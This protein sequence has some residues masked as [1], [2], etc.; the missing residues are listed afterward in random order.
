MQKVFAFLAFFSHEIWREKYRNEQKNKVSTQNEVGKIRKAETFRG[1]RRLHWCLAGWEIHGRPH[2][3]STANCDIFAPCG[4]ISYDPMT[5]KCVGWTECFQTCLSPLSFV[6][7]IVRTSQDLA[8]YHWYDCS[9][10]V[11][12]R[13]PL[14][15]PMATFTPLQMILGTPWYLGGHQQAESQERKEAKSARV[16]TKGDTTVLV[17]WFSRYY[18]SENWQMTN[19]APVSR[20]GPKSETHLNQPQC[21]RCYVSFNILVHWVQS[22][23]Q[24]VLSQLLVCWLFKAAF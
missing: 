21:F 15:H 7:R 1:P 2:S 17:V 20:P 18:T 16:L 13:F 8:V 4:I 5:K 19:I 23:E 24:Q 12:P 22:V 11:F 14:I 3:F 10:P 9:L 6:S